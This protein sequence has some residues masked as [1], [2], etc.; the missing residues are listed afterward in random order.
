MIIGLSIALFLIAV[1]FGLIFFNLFAQIKPGRKGNW[2]DLFTNFDSLINL[3]FLGMAIA[4]CGVILTF[5]VIA[6]KGIF[7]LL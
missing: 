7:L 3:H 1:G 5:I 6:I 2:F 4:G